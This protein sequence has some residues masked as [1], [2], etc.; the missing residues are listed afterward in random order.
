ME[1]IYHNKLLKILKIYYHIL[2]LYNSNVS[3]NINCYK[4]L[5]DSI[6][7]KKH[8]CSTAYLIKI[9]LS[10]HYYKKKL[11]YISFLFFF[12]FSLLIIYI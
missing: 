6:K 1:N 5:K 4:N 12:F 3:K 2:Y 11:I 9:K 7:K 10:M 8:F